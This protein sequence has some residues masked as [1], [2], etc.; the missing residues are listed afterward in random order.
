MSGFTYTYTHIILY[1][2]CI[3]HICM[4]LSLPIYIYPLGGNSCCQMSKTKY[5]WPTHLKS[6]WYWILLILPQLPS[7][8]VYSSLKSILLTFT[9]FL[10]D[11]CQ[12]NYLEGSF[13][14]FVLVWT[15]A[16]I[17]TRFLSPA[18]EAFCSEAGL[19]G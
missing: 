11:L 6:L 12:G 8:P 15:W 10:K 2:L 4:F 17:T 5:L 13:K 7:S 19:L 14:L 18:F 16:L 9:K 1:H 3:T